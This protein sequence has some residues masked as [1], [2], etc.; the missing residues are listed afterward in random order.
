MHPDVDALRDLTGG[1]RARLYAWDIAALAVVLLFA[2]LTAREI[3]NDFLWG[4]DGGNGAPNL[5]GAR[6]SLRFGVFG[7]A[8]GY[9]GLTPPTAADFYFHHPVLMHAHLVVA[10][11]V[12]G[13]A[14]WVGRLVSF[15]YSFGTLALLYVLVRRRWTAPFALAAASVYAFTPLHLVF[16][17]M[18][19]HEQ[20][21]I[22]WSLAA[23]GAATSALLSDRRKHLYL[24][25]A[26][27]TLAL[28]FAWGAHFVLCSYGLLVL[29]LAARA[30]R[31]SVARRRAVRVAGVLGVVGVVN[32]AAFAGAVQLL[33]GGFGDTTAAFANR[34]TSP[35]DYA[36]TLYERSL[37]LY[38]VPIGV[39]FAV[40]ATLFA[41][42]W[43]GGRGM[44]RDLV[45]ISFALGQ[46]GLSLGFRNA[47]Q[48][49]AYWTYSG[50][51]A[52]ALIAGEGLV[53]AS[54]FVRRRASKRV[55]ALLVVAVV[56]LQIR[57]AF[58]RKEWGLATGFASYATPY[59][60][61]YE[62]IQASKWLAERN[63]RDVTYLLHASLGARVE[64]H[65]YLDAPHVDVS[66]IPPPGEAAAAC[67]ATARCV[68]FVDLVRLSTHVDRV[69][70][71]RLVDAHP[72]VQ[73][74]DR[75]V[76]VALEAREGVALAAGEGGGSA[77][78]VLATRSAGALH[79]WFVDARHP[80]AT[81]EVSDA[82]GVRL[83]DLLGGP[84]FTAESTIRGRS[85]MELCER[86]AALT[87][88]VVHRDGA[89][90]RGVQGRCAD[91]LTRP[92]GVA[93]GVASEIGC[94]AGTVATAMGLAGAEDLS[95]VALGCG[96]PASGP[97]T[98]A[99]PSNDVAVGFLAR[100]DGPEVV[101]LGLACAPPG[102]H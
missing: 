3:G 37:D 90:V 70:L 94:D 60:D 85:V 2:A 100:V 40:G 101:G 77:H 84:S 24:L 55:F 47:G 73:F 75:F 41:N 28:Q 82:P 31:G 61:Q 15:A 66:A 42:R 33:G 34:M 78:L 36:A 58:A 53:G 98:M 59:D 35:G 62:L 39:L 65:Y 71:R 44:V 27:T 95:V 57:T 54:R 30:E 12:L 51:V 86:G 38:G 21:G 64:A 50:G 10:R 18:I 13:G 67:A 56:L 92:V 97:Y 43:L 72:A 52:I 22:F 69:A 1:A 5:A 9:V 45:A 74:D 7:P 26:A 96:G 76:A 93:E 80:P 6:A 8:K 17:T 89:R 99:C 81:Y 91:T 11:A 4:H 23:T 87:G 49:H 102:A 88:L 79:R 83:R 32:V 20:G 16:A 46:L 48:I 68:V 63:G 19:S 14:E 25:A 29:A